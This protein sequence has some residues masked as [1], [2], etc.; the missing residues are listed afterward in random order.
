MKN[1]KILIIF[2]VFLAVALA[3]ETLY[4]WKISKNKVMCKPSSYPSFVR[5]HK[6]SRPEMRKPNAQRVKIKA[7]EKIVE[8]VDPFREMEKV[9]QEMDKMFQNNFVQP[10]PRMNISLG[11]GNRFLN[12]QTDIKKTDN[13][14]I[15]QM[16]VPGMKKEEI[17][18]DV[19]GNMLTI[20]GQRNHEM[21]QEEKDAGIVS[22]EREFGFFSKSLSLPPDVNKDDI[23]ASCENG[24]LTVSLPKVVS[25]KSAQEQVT[26]IKVE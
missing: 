15:I 18:I 21:T 11:A 16:D 8:P 9:Q 13:A 20:S 24:V 3:G 19:Q 26:K 23:K 7:P 17:N 1:N 4:L 10:K 22:Q 2:V 25:E 12:P 5:K 14:Y 6:Q